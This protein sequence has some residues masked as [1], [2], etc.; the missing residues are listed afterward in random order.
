MKENIPNIMGIIHSIMFWLDCC[1]GS[2]EGVMVIFCW[3]QVVA[4]TISGMMKR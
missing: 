1:L 3:T 4:A 2:A